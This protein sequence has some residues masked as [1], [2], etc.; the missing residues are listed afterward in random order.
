MKQWE[1]LSRNECS[2]GPCPET[3]LCSSRARCLRL[4]LTVF[5]TFAM[6]ACNPNSSSQRNVLSCRS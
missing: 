2:R 4:S 5:S 1:G 3:N 6:K